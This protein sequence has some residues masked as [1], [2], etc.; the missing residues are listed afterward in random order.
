MDFF[1]NFVHLFITGLVITSFAILATYK[2]DK[3]V[4]FALKSVISSSLLVLI[5]VVMA[6]IQTNVKKSFSPYINVIYEA[7]FFLYYFFSIHYLFQL[8][9]NSVFF[10]LT[11]MVLGRYLTLVSTFMLV[12]ALSISEEFVVNPLIFSVIEIPFAAVFL[13]IFFK[14]F[15]NHYAGKQEQYANYHH[16]YFF[17]AL[18]LINLTEHILQYLLRYTSYTYLLLLALTQFFFVLMMVFI[19]YSMLREGHNDLELTMVKRLWRED[20]RHYEIQKESIDIINIK[21]HDLRHQIQDYRQ[22]GNVTDKMMQQL[23]KSIHIYDSVIKTGNEALDVILSSF[24]LRCQNKNV[25]LTTMVDGRELSFVDEIDMYSLFTNLLDNALEYEETIIEDLRFISLTVKN[26]NNFVHIHVENAYQGEKNISLNDIKT[27]KKDSVNHGYG[28][29]SIKN[30]VNK[31]DG[32]FD[33]LIAD[34][35]FQVDISLPV[36]GEQKL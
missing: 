30:I 16:I 33:V 29:K 31:Y 7:T 1:I 25:E 5:T 36:K 15:S 28:L 35:M 4:S 22:Q 21:C 19:F 20:K 24:S 32:Q 12:D 6:I 23:E 13:F 10:T 2:N 9:W 11:I 18:L 3:R 27:S 8:S 14:I 26:I 34:E 17:F